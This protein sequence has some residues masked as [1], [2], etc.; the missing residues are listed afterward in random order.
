MRASQ[1]RIA[2]LMMTVAM[3]TACPAPYTRIDRQVEADFSPDIHCLMETFRDL[4][5]QRSIHYSVEESKFGTRHVFLYVLS[6]TSYSWTFL[7][8]PN[9]NVAITHSSGVD[10]DH[11]QDLPAIRKKMKDVEG[12][13]T[14]HCGLGDIMSGATETC[15]GQA[16]D[17]A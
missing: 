7:E 2:L 13:V 15:G 9:G 14:G 10:N 8:K 4:T 16:C 17:A 5:P 12:V 1:F 3:L 11:P 6:K